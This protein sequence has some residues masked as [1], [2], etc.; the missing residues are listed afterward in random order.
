MNSWIYTTVPDPP[1]EPGSV[2]VPAMGNVSRKNVANDTGVS[3]TEVSSTE[4]SSE[5]MVFLFSKDSLLSSLRTSLLRTFP[6]SAESDAARVVFSPSLVSLPSS[7]FLE[8]RLSLL[9]N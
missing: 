3:S 9:G 8:G 6:V 1:G 2:H 7:F 4:P 5:T